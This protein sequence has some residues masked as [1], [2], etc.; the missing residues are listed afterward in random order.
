MPATAS[1]PG[2]V[3][4][5]DFDTLYEQH[6]DGVW[7]LLERLGVPPSGLEDATQEVFIVAHR[8]LPSFRGESSLKTWLGGIAVRV[9]RDARRTHARKGSRER[10]LVEA[11]AV[12]GSAPHIDD[13]LD[14]QK[15]L[16]HVLRLLAQLDEDQRA[17]FVL[18]EL[19]EL[20]A[21]E[22]SEMTGVNLNTVYTRLRAARR[23]FD[24]LL[25]AAKERP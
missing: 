8:R 21:P 2:D 3:P 7:R 12:P 23:R 4:P 9:A 25:A 17:V 5:P 24:A 13:S 22:I 16:A 11:S 1:F 6:V 14:R 19:E 20:T 10:P 18:A 15:A